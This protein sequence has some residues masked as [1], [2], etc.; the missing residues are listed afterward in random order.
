MSLSNIIG[1]NGKFLRFRRDG[2]FLKRLVTCDEKWIFYDIVI[3]KRQWCRPGEAPKPTPKKN[4]HSKKLIMCMV[5]YGRDLYELLRPNKTINSEVYCQQ[6][7]R[8]NECLK[9][10]RPHLVK[11]KGVVFHQDN[12]RPH[13]SKMTQQKIKELN[14]EISDH[15]PYSPNLAPSDYHSF[16]S[17]QNHLNNRKFERFEEVNDA[18]LAYF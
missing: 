16:R 10:K 12:A 8:V 6:L 11:R 18:I 7:D 14:W 9:E 17:L 15:P 4:L 2:P 3:R 13:V 5:G 1:L